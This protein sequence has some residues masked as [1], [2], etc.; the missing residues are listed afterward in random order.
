MKTNI[1][2]A[3]ILCFGLSAACSETAL[4]ERLDN[5]TKA[6][7]K[8]GSISEEQ[9][10][11]NISLVF[12]ALES[13]LR[14]GREVSIKRFGRFWIQDRAGRPGR[15]P[16]TGAALQIPAKKYPKFTSSD[17]LKESLNED[18]QTAAPQAAQAE[19]EPAPQAQ[20][21]P[22]AVQ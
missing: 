8:Q 19:A 5:L 13:E 18:A 15:N 22:A 14:A 21:V 4:A 17:V 6:V 2:F 1:F 20:S 12:K 7:A 11:Q 10:W 16:K 9:A 3:A